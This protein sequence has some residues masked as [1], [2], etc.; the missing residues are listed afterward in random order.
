MPS[1]GTDS[2]HRR[3]EAARA[4]VGA[5]VGVLFALPPVTVDGSVGYPALSRGIAVSFLEA[6]KVEW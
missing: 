4:G 1:S 3:V 6:I 2:R 5:G